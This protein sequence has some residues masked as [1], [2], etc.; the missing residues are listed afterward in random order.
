MSDSDIQRLSSGH[1]EDLAYIVLTA[2]A[3]GQAINLYP[4]LSDQLRKRLRSRIK[5]LSQ[6]DWPSSLRND[7]ALRRGFTLRQCC[8]LMTAL[9]M[10]DAHLPANKAVPLARQHERQFF[11]AIAQR[12]HAPSDLASP[13]D[14]IAV[15][16]SGE[17]RDALGFPEKHSLLTPPVRFIARNDL[18]H[19]WSSH[20]ADPGARL[21]LD[22]GTA[23]VALWRWISGRR[24]M[25]DAARTQLLAEIQGG[26][27]EPG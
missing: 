17:I 13:D 4:D 22:V 1:L 3:D 20:L 16:T 11:R 5:H 2:R 7:P 12:L 18:P 6:Y 14:E 19:Q 10:I 23:A 25:D 9:L 26:P 21:A 8:R 24:L 15:I 27:V